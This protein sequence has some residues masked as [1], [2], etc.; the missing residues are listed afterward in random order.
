MAISEDVRRALH[1]LVQHGHQPGG[2]LKALFEGDLELARARADAH[3]L[4]HFE[5]IQ[6]HVQVYILVLDCIASLFAVCNA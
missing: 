1:N 4:A 2:F 6:R 5:Q 3:N